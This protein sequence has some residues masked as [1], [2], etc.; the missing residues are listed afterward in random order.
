M[1]I[2]SIRLHVFTVQESK[3]L[4]NIDNNTSQLPSEICLVI[5]ESHTMSHERTYI[6]LNTKHEQHQGVI[7]GSGSETLSEALLKSYVYS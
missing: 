4:S 1:D 3:N 5:A 6:V 7:S 2:T